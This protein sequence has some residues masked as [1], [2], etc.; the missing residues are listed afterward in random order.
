MNSL[1]A[2]GDWYTKFQVGLGTILVITYN[3]VTRKFVMTY[4]ALLRLTQRF[5]G[6]YDKIV[7][8]LIR[9]KAFEDIEYGGFA[10]YDKLTKVAVCLDDALGTIKTVENNVDI[11][12]HLYV[13]K[14]WKAI[15]YL[16]NLFE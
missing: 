13:S 12:Y 15:S 6:K 1:A 16:I 2:I 14:V 8:A 9:G 10:F 11:N 5:G 4:H 7:D 3:G